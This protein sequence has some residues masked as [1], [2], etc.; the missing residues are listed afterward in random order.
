MSKRSK[1]LAKLMTLSSDTNWTVDEAVK[2]L[3]WHG[4][5]ET[6]GKGSHRVFSHST[7]PFPITLAPHGK[8]VKPVYIRQIRQA[9]ESLE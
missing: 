2:I 9:I 4:F 3:E 1:L 7:Y 6:G 8:D 5:C